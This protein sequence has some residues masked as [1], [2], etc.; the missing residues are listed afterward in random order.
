KTFALSRY[1]AFELRLEGFNVFNWAQ[2]NQPNATVGDPNFG[3][4]TGTRLNTE[5]QVQLGARFIF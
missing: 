2:Y 4:I 3:K 1:G 5:R